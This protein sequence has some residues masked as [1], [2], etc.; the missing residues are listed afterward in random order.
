MCYFILQDI[1]LETEYEGNK[2]SFTMS[3]IWPIRKPR[4]VTNK[5]PFCYPLITGKRICDTLYPLVDKIT[6]Y[7]N[8]C[9]F[10]YLCIYVLF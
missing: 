6:N 1:L 2:T 10:L 8:K 4:P 5:L 9:L 3:Q 7:K